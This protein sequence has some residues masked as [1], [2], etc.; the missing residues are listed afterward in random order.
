VNRRKWDCDRGYTVVNTG[1][2]PRTLSSFRAARS[3]VRSL[4]PGLQLIYGAPNNGASDKR[5]GFD[6]YAVD[7]RLSVP[8]I[9][10]A[11]ILV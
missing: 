5:P 8:F 11:T 7:T 1:K 2:E 10:V 3:Y 4:N 6:V 9:I